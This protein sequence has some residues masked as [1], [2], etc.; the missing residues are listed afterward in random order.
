[1]NPQLQAV[2]WFVL[3]ILFALL[4]YFGTGKNAYLGG[5]AFV[6]AIKMFRVTLL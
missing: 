6:L 5:A 4:V 1:M 3:C 2:I